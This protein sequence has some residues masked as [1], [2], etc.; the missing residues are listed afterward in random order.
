[1]FSDLLKVGAGLTGVSTFVFCSLYFEWLQIGIFSTISA[2]H[3]FISFIVSLSLLFLFSTFILVLHY[4]KDKKNSNIAEANDGGV[5]VNNIGSG[6][7]N[8]NNKV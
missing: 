7:V 2:E 4:K 8:I 6:N 1:M 5:A 3:T